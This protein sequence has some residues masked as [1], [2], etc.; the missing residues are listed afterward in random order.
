MTVAFAEYG[1]RSKQIKTNMEEPRI[2]TPIH[3]QIVVVIIIELKIAN[4]IIQLTIIFT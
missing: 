4:A 1:A 3:A 2:S